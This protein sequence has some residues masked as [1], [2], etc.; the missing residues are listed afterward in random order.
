MS[1]IYI[2]YYSI[3][4]INHLS[5][6]FGENWLQQHATCKLVINSQSHDTMFECTLRWYKPVLWSELHPSVS[7]IEKGLYG[8][9]LPLFSCYSSH[10]PTYTLSHLLDLCNC[11]HIKT[12]TTMLVSKQ[13]LW[14]SLKR[15]GHSNISSALYKIIIG[16]STQFQCRILSL[17]LKYI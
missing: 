12:K 8:R 16:S 10:S 7:N 9:P 1:Y 15:D 6:T 13:F 17:C 11:R 5:N 14:T 4:I 3:R 2:T